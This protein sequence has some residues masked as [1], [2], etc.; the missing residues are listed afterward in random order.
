MNWES[1]LLINVFKICFGG[2]L[3]Y[4]ME[5]MYRGYSPISMFLLGGLCFLGCG[6][7][8]KG[9]GPEVC[10][11]KKMIVCMVIITI[12]EFVTGIFVN[13]YMHLGVWTYRGI[14]F[15]VM[16]Q[17]CL[18][19]MIMWFFLSFPAILL[20]NIIDRSCQRKQT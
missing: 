10:A 14:P 19:Y 13:E 20:N 12:G 11:W 16:G 18:P 9:L 8:N 5:I 1:V 7:I 17:I 4:V 6:F 2:A 3:Y 15:E